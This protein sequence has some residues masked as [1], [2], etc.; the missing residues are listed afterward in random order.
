MN[1]CFNASTGVHLFSGFKLRHRS[2]RS[3]KRFSS[4]LSTSSIVPFALASNLVLRSRV[5]LVR[6]RIRV[7]SY[8]ST[9]ISAI[10]P[11]FNKQTKTAPPLHR[12]ARTNHELPTL[13]DSRSFS[14]LRKFSKSSKWRPANWALRRILW[15]NL[16]LHSIIARSIWL[17][18]RPVK[19]I[20]PVYN[21]KSVHPTD[22]ISIP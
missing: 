14:R 3:T 15:L 4:L 20:F 18:L 19:R 2:N 1:G 11:K 8:N 9:I 21:S 7:M 12:K 13:P 22:Q 5:G 6:L 10:M 16:P 17:L